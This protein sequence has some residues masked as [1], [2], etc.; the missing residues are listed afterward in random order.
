MKIPRK[1]RKKIYRKIRRKICMKIRRKFR[2]KIQGVEKERSC[3]WIWKFVSQAFRHSI[4]VKTKLEDVKEGVAIDTG[5]YQRL[6]GKLIYLSHTH[7]NIAFA[8]SMV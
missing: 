5:R 1:I 3:L 4:E 6:A 7:P 8:V 2:K